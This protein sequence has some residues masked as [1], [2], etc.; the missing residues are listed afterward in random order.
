M[1]L[2][3]FYAKLQVELHSIFQYITEKLENYFFPLV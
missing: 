3:V 1:I 2:V